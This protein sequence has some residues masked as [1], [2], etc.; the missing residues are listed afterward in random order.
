M[1]LLN[2]KSNLLCSDCSGRLSTVDEVLNEFHQVSGITQAIIDDE[3]AEF[4]RCEENSSESSVSY[5][6]TEFSSKVTLTS[7]VIHT[8]LIAVTTRTRV[9][10]RNVSE[11]S[12]NIVD[13]IRNH[14]VCDPN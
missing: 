6:N 11:L 7:P 2:S 13:T 8:K 5:T 9:L 1:G 3:I 12:V 10:S 4:E 14:Q